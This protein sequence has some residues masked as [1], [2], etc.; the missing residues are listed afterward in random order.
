[1]PAGRKSAMPT[2]AER[3]GFARDDRVAI[4]HVDD[5]GMCD[6]QSDGGFE[7][8][9]NG[10]AT[11]GSLMVP[12]PGFEA[13]AERARAEPDLDLGVHLTL[14]SEWPSLRWGPVLGPE[15]VPSLVDADGLLPR[16]AA[17]VVA[18]ARPEEVAAELRAQV[19]RALAAGVDVTHLDSHMGTVFFPSLVPVY[20]GLMREFRLPGLLVRPDPAALARLGA[21]AGDRYEEVI[22]GLESDGWP[23]LDAFDADSL[24]FPPGTGAEHNRARLQ[25]LDEG[26]TYLI[27]HPARGGDE[28]GS[29]VN[30]A[31]ARDFE[32]SF[33]GGE[34][35]HRALAELGIR[36]SGMRALRELVAGG[37]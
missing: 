2:T 15:A 11:C 3:L 12:C 19:E 7:A 32:R 9:C 17:E 36:T 29:I 22:G 20:A 24:D 6:A 18:R 23:V 10:P 30:E 4:V 21:E 25:K 16:T 13:A 5:I 14:T 1:M 35:G 37:A 34:A 8:L 27:C 26:V 33:Y 28:L 31:H